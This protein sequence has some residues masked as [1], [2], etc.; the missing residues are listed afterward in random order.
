MVMWYRF[1]ACG[2]C[3]QVIIRRYVF[4]DSEYTISKVCCC[5][6]K[7]ELMESGIRRM[8]GQ[9]VVWQEKDHE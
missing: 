3:G 5:S 1:G 4:G 8:E 6:S 2:W 7:F 9:M